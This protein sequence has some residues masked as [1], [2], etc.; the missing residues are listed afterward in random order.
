MGRHWRVLCRGVTSDMCFKNITLTRF[1]FGHVEL[2]AIPT[3]YSKRIES[4]IWISGGLLRDTCVGHQWLGDNGSHRDWWDHQRE[5][6]ECK[7]QWSWDGALRE[8][9]EEEECVMGAQQIV[10]SGSRGKSPDKD[11]SKQWL[12]HAKRSHR[13]RKGSIG[14]NDM[15][16]IDGLGK[17]SFIRVVMGMMEEEGK[18]IDGVRTSS[19]RLAVKGSRR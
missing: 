7:V 13:D 14:L 11:I 18:E 4:C 3:G 19:P 5:C 6:T 15:G 12:K 17:S 16:N 2:R 9:R 8:F 10:A 1:I